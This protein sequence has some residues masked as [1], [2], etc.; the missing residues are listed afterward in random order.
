M[1]QPR[2]P[3]PE[4]IADRCLKPNAKIRVCSRGPNERLLRADWRAKVP[5]GIYVYTTDFMPVA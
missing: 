5:Y 2:A 3:T 1:N 4:Q